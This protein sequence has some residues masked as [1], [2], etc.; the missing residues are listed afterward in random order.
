MFCIGKRL[1]RLSASS[2]QT[3]RTHVPPSFSSTSRTASKKPPPPSPPGHGTEPVPHPIFSST[4]N[5]RPRLIKRRKA[6]RVRK[7]SDEEFNRLGPLEQI[8]STFSLPRPTT[9]PR[10]E[11][12]VLDAALAIT[13]NEKL[14]AKTTPPGFAFC[15]I[16]QLALHGDRFWAGIVLEVLLAIKSTFDPGQREK[17]AG[18]LAFEAGL[19][20]S[21]VLAA[22]YAEDLGLGSHYKVGDAQGA[23]ADLWE[24]YLVA[25]YYEKGRQARLEFLVP[26]VKAEYK[27]LDVAE[28]RAKF[29][30]MK[31][32]EA[33]H[34]AISF[35]SRE[36]A[37]KHFF[38][39][40]D[41]L[42]IP[43]LSYVSSGGGK[44]MLQLPGRPLLEGRTGSGQDRK[45]GLLN[46]LVE[47]ALT[48]GY[49]HVNSSTSTNATRQPEPRSVHRAQSP[50]K[51][52]VPP[53]ARPVPKPQVVKTRAAAK[54]PK[55]IQDTRPPYS[56]PDTPSPLKTLPLVY[57]TMHKARVS[58]FKQLADLKIGF[59][60]WKSEKGRY[61]LTLPGF[62]PIGSSA[63]TKALRRRAFVDGAIA[64]GAIKIQSSS[65]SP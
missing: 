62:D 27:L 11:W 41:N 47:K 5:K 4:A 22:K 65:S 48:L 29:E 45:T 44:A 17:K 26:L 40:L 31:L 63:S 21:N 36:A 14:P 13:A 2:T 46:R 6:A 8:R 64:L 42:N 19:L 15:G 37:Q 18:L 49:F 58:F 39:T 35:V 12:S 50:P 1:V 43:Y 38:S 32:G 7:L 28:T 10:L 34:K 60:Y 55:P 16:K 23:L 52:P 25:L 53:K 20:L 33:I 59:T 24:A 51:S 9:F 56:C 30:A 61:W 57:S 3:F 54:K